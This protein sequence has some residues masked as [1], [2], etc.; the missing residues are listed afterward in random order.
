MR[1]VR[2]TEEWIMSVGCVHAS[3]MVSVVHSAC[4]LN[5][6]WVYCDGI[7]SGSRESYERIMRVV[8]YAF[9]AHA[10]CVPDA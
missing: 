3:C 9:G 5:V 6:V 4:V 8:Q 2:L 1:T 7:M 10:L